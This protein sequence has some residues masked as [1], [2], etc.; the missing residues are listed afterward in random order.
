MNYSFLRTSEWV[1]GWGVRISFDA[2]R[3]AFH[4]V[5]YPNV[6]RPFISAWSG[7][8]DWGFEITTTIRGVWGYHY[9]RR[10]RVVV[11]RFDLTVDF[12]PLYRMLQATRKAGGPAEPIVDWLLD[13]NVPLIT[14]F[15]S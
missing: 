13:Q 8:F 15:L 7:A 3:M 11:T 2:R 1:D 9:L 12:M 10:P 14:E 4:H 5:Q 6:E